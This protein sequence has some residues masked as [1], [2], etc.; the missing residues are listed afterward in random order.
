MPPKAKSAAK[1]KGAKKEKGL[2]KSQLIAELAPRVELT[3][4]QVSE[5]FAALSD[6]IAAELKGGRDITIPGLV[7]ITLVH[8]AAT[9]ARPGI[10]PF[11]Q[12]AIMI[13]AK[14][15]RKV[16]KTRAVKALKDMA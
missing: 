9:A 15:A 6:L 7:K 10:N 1:K 13:K 3:K 11:T 14:P 12:E 4:S 8:K 2:T 5:V 16:V